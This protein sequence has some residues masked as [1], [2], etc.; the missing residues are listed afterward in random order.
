MSADIGPQVG[1]A[2]LNYLAI[3]AYTTPTT[4]TDH[5][6]GLRFA[7][8][9]PAS[10]GGATLGANTFTGTQAAPAF[11]G[12]GA[13][14]VNVNAAMLDGLDSRAFALTVHGH[15]VAQ[16][17]GAAK[18]A[19][20]NLFTGTQ[21]LNSGHLDLDASTS[22]TGTIRKGGRLFLH[23]FGDRNTFLGE[24]AGN[25]SLTG[26][27]NT[28]LG[29]NALT[30]NTTGVGNTAQGSSAL[31]NN[32]IGGDNVALGQNAGA[33]LT[34]GSNNIYLGANVLGNTGDKNSIYLGLQGL[35][36]QTV[37][38]GIRGTTVASGEMVVIDAN[39]R[40]G[41]GAVAP[42]ANTVGSAQVIDG[43]LTA[44]DVAFTYAG[45]LSKGGAAAD[46][47]CV[48][49]VAASEVSFSF[50]GTGANTF[51]DTQT[52]DGGNLDL[53]ASSSTAGNV[54]K[55]GTPFLHD[56]GFDNVFLG[57]N[58]GN[59][60]MTGGSNMASGA[61]TLN[62]N[63]QGYENTASGAYALAQNVWGFDNTGTG[64]YTLYSNTTGYHNAASGSYALVSN[65]TGY[66]NTAAGVNALASNTTG[67][68]N[69]AVGHEALFSNTGTGNVAVGVGAGGSATT[70][71]DNI[72]LGAGV[73]GVPG[74]SNTMYLGKQGGVTRT[75]IAGIR[76]TTTGINNAVGVVIDSNGQLG[77]INSSRRVKEDIHDMADTS[78]RLLQL[79]PVTFRYTRAY[80]DGARPIQYGLIAEEVADVFP[81]LAVRNADGQ[82]ETVHYETL[83]VLLLNEF[84]KLSAQVQSLK[85]EME[86]LRAG[87]AHEN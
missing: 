32:M 31:I 69:T 73:F 64:S 41:S 55:N 26:D 10:S 34:T 5:I 39:G 11:T 38:A 71:S 19:G 47:A 24:Q 28:A 68:A 85:E 37:I 27:S 76:G 70:G 77:T 56:Y 22:A 14:L 63:T 21:T 29:F 44:A 60:T 40:L 50:V 20:G 58:A 3:L 7:Y 57:K 80:L 25:L 81:E 51:T 74:E 45:S 17:T 78:R 13:G 35:H 82:V 65:T 53:D 33:N 18:L 79:R 87:L 43:S 59:F 16:V 2:G 4:T 23:N 8:D 75:L 86:S 72:Y 1:T 84:Q 9:P 30:R 66:F 42:G 48:A 83:N 61:Q 54:T 49:C 15:D 46:L 6:V 12:G 52:I 36:T 62:S 67:G